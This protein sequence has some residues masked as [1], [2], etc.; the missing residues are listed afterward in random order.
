[1]DKAIKKYFPIFMLPTMVAFTIGFV[2]PFLLGIYLSLCE[3]T[4]VTDAR[5]VGFKN[6]AKVFSD[7]T[8]M[9]SLW[10]TVLFSIFSYPGPGME[11]GNRSISTSPV[12]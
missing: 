2:L 7:E 3:F 12:K 10:F 9:H 8:F 6:F 4:T 5:F 11:A 1:M